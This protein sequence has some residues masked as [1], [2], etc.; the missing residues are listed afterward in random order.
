MGVILDTSVIIAFER[1][2]ADPDFL[3]RGREEESFGICAITAAELLHGVHLADTS[4]RRI[5]RSSF[6]EKVLEKYP[7]YAFDLAAARVYAEL[8][9]S[10]RTRKTEIGAHGLMIAATA[11]SLG[12]SVATFN[13]RDYQ[14]IEGLVL[15]PL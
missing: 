15:L 14:K 13:R 2:T 11:I 1:G 5:K 6:V 3:I 12:F 10:L 8:W 7:I 9:S 4:G